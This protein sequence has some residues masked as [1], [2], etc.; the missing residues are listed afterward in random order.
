VNHE[1]SI[2]NN[3]TGSIYWLVELLCMCSGFKCLYGLR[4]LIRQTM[5]TGLTKWLL[6]H[7]SIC[8]LPGNASEPAIWRSCYQP[9]QSFN[10]SLNKKDL[11]DKKKIDSHSENARCDR[12]A[13]SS[14]VS[15]CIAKPAYYYF[16][17]CIPT[18]NV[19]ANADGSKK[20]R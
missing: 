16:D 15:I 13:F 1:L 17:K 11:N 14:N 7:T 18:D 12:F 20:S 9:R 6:Q 8:N 4:R 19:T 2:F 3:V 5:N 10:Y